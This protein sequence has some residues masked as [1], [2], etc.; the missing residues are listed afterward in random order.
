MARTDV[1]KSS[2]GAFER[3]LFFA[4]PI[5]F[6]VVLLGVLF[7]MFD[8]SLLN[9][10]LRTA[11]RIPVLNQII[12]DPAKPADRTTPAKTG[13]T[14]TTPDAQVEELKNTIKQL[15]ADLNATDSNNQKKDQTIKDLNAKVAALEEQM[16]TKSQTDEE[17][18]A[19]VQQLANMYAKMLPSKSAPILENMTLKEAVLVLSEMKPD[20]RGKVLEKMDPKKAADASIQLKDIVPSKDRQ[21]AALQE[22]LEVNQAQ[23]ATPQQI[24][25]EDLGATFSAMDA[26]SAATILL[27]MNTLNQAKVMSIL[28][29]MD[30]AARSRVLAEISKTNKAIAATLSSK[31]TQ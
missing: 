14:E 21:M 13:G 9:G 16:K 3:F 17:Y 4:T 30:S 2:Y 12:P 26:K 10:M 1:E 31:L 25:K 23:A 22:R 6:T 7:A 5:I 20:D 27:E 15:E 19:Q 24:S 11:N 29:T 18:R 8:Q 28:S